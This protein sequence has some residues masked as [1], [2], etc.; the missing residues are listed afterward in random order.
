MVIEKTAESKD[1]NSSFFTAS[2][3]RGEC[4]VKLNGRRELNERFDF[5]LVKL[6]RRRKHS[7]GQNTLDL[8]SVGW[9]LGFQDCVGC[10]FP[11]FLKGKAF[12]AIS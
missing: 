8:C 10:K 9:S 4:I 2:R 11:G 3:K 12:A 5:N 7:S 6:K 1:S